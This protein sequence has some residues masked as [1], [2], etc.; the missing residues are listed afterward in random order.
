MTK[1][2]AWPS[3]GLESKTNSL[4]VKQVATTHRG[5]TQA[6]KDAYRTLREL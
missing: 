3:R 6:I 2:W 4:Q 1:R 5:E